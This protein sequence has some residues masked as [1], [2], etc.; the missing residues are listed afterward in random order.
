M[1]TILLLDIIKY[2]KMEMPQIVLYYIQYLNTFHHCLLISL[3]YGHCVKCP[4]CTVLTRPQ[5]AVSL[6]NIL[7]GTPDTPTLKHYL[8]VQSVK[9]HWSFAAG[10]EH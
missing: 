8:E 1:Y 5:M 9:P 3:H 4:R 10:K 6:Y 2:H 7:P